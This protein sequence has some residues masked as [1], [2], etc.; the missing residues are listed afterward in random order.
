[1]QHFNGHPREA[2]AAGRFNANAA[3]V[4]SKDLFGQNGRRNFH[5]TTVMMFA[6]GF[7]RVLLR[8]TQCF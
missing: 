7:G 5:H 1:M 6:F 2:T 8:V 3:A 4:T